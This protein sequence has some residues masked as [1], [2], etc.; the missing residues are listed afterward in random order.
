MRYTVEH[1]T[2]AAPRGRSK[3]KAMIVRG[4]G[5]KEVMGADYSPACNAIVGLARHPHPIVSGDLFK[6]PSGE[7]LRVIGQR[8]CEMDGEGLHAVYLS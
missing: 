8:F 4:V 6:L 2:C 3:H 7:F 1:H 5:V